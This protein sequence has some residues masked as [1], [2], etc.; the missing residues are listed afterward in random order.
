LIGTLAAGRLLSKLFPDRQGGRGD[1]AFGFA[2]GAGKGAVL[3]FAALSLL[4]FFE[5][6]LTQALGAPPPSVRKSRIVAFTRRHDLFEAVP[7]PALAGLQKLIDAAKSPGG[8]RG[9]ENQP[10][11]R[12]LLDDPRLRAA[13]QDD[14]LSQALKSGDLS[15]LRNDPRLKALLDDPRLAAPPADATTR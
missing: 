5:K 14:A 6:P 15:S 1:R 12:R 13:L 10:E 11:L 2:L 3:V 7:V 9:L 8:M 4:L